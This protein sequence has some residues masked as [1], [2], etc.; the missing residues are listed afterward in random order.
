MQFSISDTAALAFPR[1]FYTALAS[2]RSIDE[3]VRSGRIE[4]L[5]IGQG[6]LEWVTPVLYVR[7]AST[8]CSTSPNQHR[9]PAP[10]GGPRQRADRRLRKR[11]TRRP[12]T[13]ILAA[14][15]IVAVVGGIVIGYLVRG[16]PTSSPYRV[17]GTV[18]V[19]KHPLGLVVDPATHTLYVA[20]L[21]NDTVSVIDAATRKVTATLPV[22]RY[23]SGVTIDPVTHRV[24][25]A[26]AY[27]DTLSVIADSAD[28]SVETIP[29]R[30]RPISDRCGCK[31]EPHHRFR[32]ELR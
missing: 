10:H 26:N 11:L 7:G 15:A 3:A 31:P 21:G 28:R 6:T 12:I 13:P 27:S 17:I 14:G 19:G 5:G 30:R 1:G 23:P 32:R 2:G 24:Y 25:V 8:N 4:I 20:D 29:V 18:P 22:G 16:N 9:Q